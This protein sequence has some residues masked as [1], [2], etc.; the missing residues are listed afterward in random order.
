MS[1]DV[2]LELDVPL[3][4]VEEDVVPEDELLEEL[5]VPA[6]LVEPVDPLVPVVPGAAI[7]NDVEA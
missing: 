5:P 2:E 3:D 4:D 6:E 7:V 1:D